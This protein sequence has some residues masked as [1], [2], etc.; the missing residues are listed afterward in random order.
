MRTIQFI[1]EDFSEDTYTV[2]ISPV[3]MRAYFDF[4]AQWSTESTVEQFMGELHRFVELAHPAK[5]GDPLDDAFLDE[6][7]AV[8]R[9]LVNHWIEAIR[10]VA[11]PLL[12]GSSG[13]TPSGA[14]Q[15]RRPSSSGR[16][17]STRS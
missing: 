9:A 16:R 5:N 14:G 7:F 2:Q 6:D 13:T 10:E 1:F 11:P 15:T 8:S 4:T 12:L 17:R 3:S